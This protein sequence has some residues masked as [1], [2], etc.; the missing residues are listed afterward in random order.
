MWPPTVPTVRPYCPQ[1][2]GVGSLRLEPA[3]SET[4]VTAGVATKLALSAF[5]P[6]SSTPP[7]L[8]PSFR[9]LLCIYTYNPTIHVGRERTVDSKC[10]SLPQPLMYHSFY[11]ILS[12]PVSQAPPKYLMLCDFIETTAQECS[13]I[14]AFSFRRSAVLFSFVV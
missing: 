6:V 5:P 7:S 13:L 12:P 2:Q 11:K 14:Q 4:E 8:A 3:V 1:W 10:H 9:P